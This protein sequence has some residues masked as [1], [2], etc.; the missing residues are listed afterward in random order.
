MNIY[1]QQ[2]S[3]KRTTMMLMGAFFLLFL[4][5]GAGF[6]YF[7]LSFNP[8]AAEP[9]YKMNSQGYYEVHNTSRQL[10]P[11]GTIGALLF[12]GIMVLNSV[13]NGPKMVL[14]STMARRAVSSKGRAAV[15]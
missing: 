2:E 6:D 15:H 3:N 11:Y 12:G 1:D 4:A 14:R 10:I 7:Y 13:F 8:A 5:V 9:V